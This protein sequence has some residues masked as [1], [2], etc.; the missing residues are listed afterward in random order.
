MSRQIEAA[1]SNIVDGSDAG[2]SHC[3]RDN[4]CKEAVHRVGPN[5]SLSLVAHPRDGATTGV[6][7]SFSDPGTSL[8]AVW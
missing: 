3:K 1:G 6:C 8:Y 7:W 4:A 5:S 2:K